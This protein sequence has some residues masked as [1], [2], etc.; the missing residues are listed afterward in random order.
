MRPV[1]LC[2]AFQESAARVPER[3]ALR[4]PG[5]AI[6]LTWADYA[7]AVERMARALAALGVVRAPRRAPRH[8]PSMGG[9]T[10][11]TSASWTTR[12]GYDCSGARRRSSSPPTVITRLESALQDACPLILHACAIGEGRSHMAAIVAI[13]PTREH[14]DAVDG[15]V[16][17]AIELV[18][19][20]LDT[21]E[22]IEAHTIVADP[23]LPGAELTETFKLRRGCI[24]ERYAS[25]VERMYGS[26]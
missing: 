4:V 9:C 25:A 12:A 8:S 20:E 24:N 16:L 23:W 11:V 22:R 26:P 21:R 18:N 3:I 14:D 2:E 6:Q 19:A 17:A 1:T 15:A 7:A 13:D 5:D 10:P